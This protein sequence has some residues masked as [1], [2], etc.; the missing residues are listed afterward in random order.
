MSIS[1]KKKPE[2]KKEFEEVRIRKDGRAGVFWVFLLLF[3]PI[4]VEDKA[5]SL[6][7]YWFESPVVMFRLDAKTWPP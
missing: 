6:T 5:I 3:V 4:V 1:A 2:E 7:V